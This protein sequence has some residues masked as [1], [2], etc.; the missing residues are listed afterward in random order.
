[1]ILANEMAFDQGGISARLRAEA[2]ECHLFI[3]QDAL[4][5]HV[6]N[7]DTPLYA[8]TDSVLPDAQVA[9][10]RFL[11]HRASSEIMVKLLT[12]VTAEILE[13]VGP[14]GRRD[15]CSLQMQVS[16]PNPISIYLR[17]QKT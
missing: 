1:M 2:Y 3:G 15:C 16:L 5:F 10:G 11:D 8:L 9:T 12:Q 13:V 4:Q 14:S 17:F 7:N 6:Y